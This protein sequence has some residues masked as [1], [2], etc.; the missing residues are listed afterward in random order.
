MKKKVE[1]R[2]K[3]EKGRS[4]KEMEKNERNVKGRKGNTER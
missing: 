2:K 4:K 3:L 1:V